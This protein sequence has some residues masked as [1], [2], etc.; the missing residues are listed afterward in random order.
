MFKKLGMSKKAE[1]KINA[2]V[3]I[4]LLIIGAP[5]LLFF[6]FWVANELGFN[7]FQQITPSEEGGEGW[8]TPPTEGDL[9]VNRKLAIA[10]VDKFSGSKA[11]SWTVKVY[12]LDG[13][14]LIETGTSDGTSGVYTTTN[15]FDSGDKL[16]IEA[17]SGNNKIRVKLLVPK[18]AQADVDAVTDNPFAIN[19]FTIPGADVAISVRDSA[20][21]SYSDGGSLNKT[22]FG[23]TGTLTVMLN[24]PTDNEGYISSYDEIDAL[25]WYCILYAKLYNT[26]YEYVSLS[27]WTVQYSKG[28]ATW[29][30]HRMQDTD[31]TRYKV[32]NEYIYDGS[33]SFTFSI[34]LTGYS[35]AVADIE[36]YVQGYSD[37]SYHDAKGSF[38]P[39][40]YAIITSSPFTLN[41]VE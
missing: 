3:L 39:D 40:S 6:G 4:V 36:F 10:L 24:L 15:Y 35:G 9:K 13:K 1:T 37:W 41:L 8:W 26:N 30:A 34:D 22:T 25:N 38:G 17:S 20:G 14:T 18:M 19:T 5:T 29:H 21:T 23:N 27:G 31:V 12:G 28:T 11:T 7:P 33:S 2:L 32:G 16:V